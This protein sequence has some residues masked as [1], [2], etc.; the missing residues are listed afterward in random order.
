MLVIWETSTD[1]IDS[2]IPHMHFNKAKKN[3]FEE[4][5]EN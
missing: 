4:R 2:D 3:V 5:G 1:D